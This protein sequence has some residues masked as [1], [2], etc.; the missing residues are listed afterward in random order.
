MKGHLIALVKEKRGLWSTNE[1]VYK[2]K[3]IK[4]NDWQCVYEK[5]KEKYGDPLVKKHKMS[6][7]DDIRKMWHSLR[8]Y[9]RILLKKV[10]GP[11]TSGKGATGK[12]SNSHKFVIIL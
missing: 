7:P 2:N 9:Y 12:L 10:S 8:N 1:S 4:T 11:G 6:S 5:M 3:R